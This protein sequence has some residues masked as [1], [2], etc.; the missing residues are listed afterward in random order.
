[1]T[2]DLLQ[3]AFSECDSIERY[4]RQASGEISIGDRRTCQAPRMSGQCGADCD[5]VILKIMAEN[6][7]EIIS[8]DEWRLSSRQPQTEKCDYIIFDK[9]D[10][11]YKFALCELTCSLEKYVNADEIES[12]IGKRAKAFDQMRTTLQDIIENDNPVAGIDIFQYRNKT[13]IFGWRDRLA[14]GNSMAM[15]SA[16]GFMTTPGSTAGIKRFPEYLFGK[17][18]TF[19][20]VKYPA[21]YR[22]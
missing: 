16:R 6:E 17:V 14:T 19:V 9:G 20:Q 8:Y 7:L 5:E 4:V 12:R 10:E 1:M 15:R 11:K 13:G 22:W 2:R 21:V 3:I 18:F